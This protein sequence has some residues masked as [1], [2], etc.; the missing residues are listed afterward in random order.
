MRTITVNAKTR[1]FAIL[2]D[3]IAHSMSPV[4]MNSAFDRLGMDCVFLAL[5]ADL[6]SFDRVM[7]AL[8]LVE[9][10]G[11]V[12]TMPVKEAA[13]RHMD[14]LGD[15]AQIIGAVN[16]AVSRDGVLTGYNTDSSGFWS[17]VQE[18]RGEARPIRKA[19]ILGAGGFARAAAAQAALQGVE[20]LVVSN[21]L[22]HTAFV[23]SFRRFADRIALRC[24]RTRLRL[25]DWDPAL[26]RRELPACGLVANATPNGMRDQ[27]D[28]DRI[29]PYGAAAPGTLFFD[30]VYEPPVT[31]FLKRA[32]ALG[33][34]TVAGLDLLAHQGVC[35]FAHWT[36]VQVPPEQMRR[37]VLAFWA[38][39]EGQ[40][41]EEGEGI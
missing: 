32:G 23:E 16:C 9:L 8:R 22:S 20:E 37:D 1:L 28:L 31:R 34:S 11:Y 41:T 24:P 27:G 14:A 40:Q 6:A 29:F 26:W 12:F 35:S 2:G 36:G 30:A 15:E 18:G 7:E 4:I 5:R 3:P 21:P 33:F 39:R 17:A 19:L 10:E 25:L 13:L 38:A